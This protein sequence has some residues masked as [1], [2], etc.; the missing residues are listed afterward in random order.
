MS[1]I[2]MA[3]PLDRDCSHVPTYV[4]AKRRRLPPIPLAPRH[5][6]TWRRFRRWCSCGL[7]WKTCPDKRFPVPVEPQVAWGQPP[8][9]LPNWH[10]FTTARYPS[11]GRAGGLTPGQEWRAN[12][13]RW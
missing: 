2:Y 6:L 5:R 3:L 12:R 4:M 10:R 8:P 1:P 7:R 13:G 9:N 11:V